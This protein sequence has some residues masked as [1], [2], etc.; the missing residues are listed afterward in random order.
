M[1]ELRWIV[2]GDRERPTDPEIALLVSADG[3]PAERAAVRLGDVGYEGDEVLY[4]IAT[5]AWTERDLAG[6]EVTLSLHARD[7]TLERLGLVAGAFETSAPGA[8]L[9]VSATLAATPAQLEAL[10]DEATL[11]IPFDD[12]DRRRSRSGRSAPVRSGPSSSPTAAPPRP[13]DHASSGP[14]TRSARACPS[15]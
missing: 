4:V 9:L 13:A 3:P 5:D 7:T 1:A 10:N 6:G 14:M 11:V 2:G 8:R 12:A 15:A